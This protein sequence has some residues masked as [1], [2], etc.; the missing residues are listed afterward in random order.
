M[1][2][3]LI[4]TAHSVGVINGLFYIKMQGM[5]NFKMSVI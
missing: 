5:D 2:S 3:A 4:K 1:I